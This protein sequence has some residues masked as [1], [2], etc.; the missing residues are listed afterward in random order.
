MGES[1][2]LKP[3]MPQLE[4]PDLELDVQPVRRPARPIPAAAA[5]S[6]STSAARERGV[7]SFFDDDALMA[8]SPT[9]ELADDG[10]QY[11]AAHLGADFDALGE[12]ELMGNAH[13]D[14]NIRSGAVPHSAGPASSVTGAQS[15][16]WPTG[17]APARDQLAIDALELRLLANY[18]E[19]P[20]NAYSTPAYAFRVFARQRELKATLGQLEAERARA[21]AERE[22]VLAELARTVRPDT[23]RS[24]PF[25]RLVAPLVELEQV[26]SARGHALTSVNAELAAQAKALDTELATIN[27]Q[28]VGEQARERDARRRYDDCE[29]AAKRAEAK[30]KRVH[31][32]IRAVT[33][34]AKQK[35]APHAG[36]LAETEA[37]E[38]AA[39]KQRA[40]AA[41]PEVEQ[42]KADLQRAKVVL[43]QASALVGTARQS[44]RL[45]GRKKRALVAHYQHELDLRGRGLSE[46]QEQER[47]ALA[48]L[49]RAVLAA[50]GS[51]PVPEAWLER[52][53]S[54]SQRADGLLLR[55]EMQR[56]ALD[57]YDR[58]QVLQ[59]V[60]LTLTAL[61]LVVFL[62][63]LKIAW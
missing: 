61:A 12:S 63:V 29:A 17:H 25:Q 52:V 45:V 5:P 44:E 9:I 59:G 54:A 10:E 3:A 4:I 48:D 11:R 6:L 15:N 33:E 39:L 2:Q 36:S 56:R 58:A 55:S 14:L 43:D 21:D 27:E 50:G 20:K 41:Q 28:L 47:A 37:G 18:G 53:R 1:E 35:L 8:G 62:I 31:I 60:R 42:T 26:A 7:P 46:S 32:E 24:E 49:G 34:V 13:C 22:S 38:L 23:V 30:L 16:H 40:D 57:A 51:V 19:P